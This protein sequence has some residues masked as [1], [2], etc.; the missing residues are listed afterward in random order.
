MPYSNYETRATRFEVSE[1][2]AQIACSKS[3]Y[4]L[5]I[6]DH[7]AIGETQYIVTQYEEG[8]DLCNYMTALG[9][10]RLSE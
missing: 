4:V 3:E 6:F 1:V 8:Q 10:D 5:G 2:D 9:Q 7:F